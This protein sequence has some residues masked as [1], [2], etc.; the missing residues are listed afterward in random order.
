ML[1]ST[2]T[3]TFDAS[4]F[5]HI[6]L[7]ADAAGRANLLS[8][9]KKSSCFFFTALPVPNHGT[10]L[11]SYAWKFGVALRLDV[12]LFSGQSRWSIINRCSTVV[13]S[14]LDPISNYSLICMYKDR[15]I[16]CQSVVHYVS[17]RYCR[18]ID[19][20]ALVEHTLPWTHQLS[21]PCIRMY[22]R[23]IATYRLGAE[24]IMLDVPVAHP[25]VH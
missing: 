13:A 14:V 2:I 19:I 24:G 25:H 21:S 8:V 9:R 4:A 6:F 17:H 15:Q 20:N 12:T 11:A 18:D 5:A 3:S 22:L 1:P 23:L 10:Y 7:P 16:R